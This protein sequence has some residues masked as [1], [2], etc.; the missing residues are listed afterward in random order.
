MSTRR[1][2]QMAR[3]KWNGPISKGFVSGCMACDCVREI[4][5]GKVTYFINDTVSEKSPKCEKGGV[6]G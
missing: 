5:R 1:E 3:H 4:I 6:Q 2:G